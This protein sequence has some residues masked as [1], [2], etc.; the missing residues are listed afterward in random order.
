[1]SHELSGKLYEAAD[2]LHYLARL[3]PVTLDEK[4]TIVLARLFL[5]AAKEVKRLEDSRIEN[6]R[7]AGEQ[8]H[9]DFRG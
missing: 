4:E 3:P 1:M 7:K 9:A 5:Y 2:L 8:G 6:A